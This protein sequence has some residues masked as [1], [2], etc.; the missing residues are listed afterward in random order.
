VFVGSRMTSNARWLSNWISG[1]RHGIGK[2]GVPRCVGF[3]L[4]RLGC[5]PIVGVEDGEMEYL[6]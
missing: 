2:E 4:S 5:Q 3:H 1:G 6:G